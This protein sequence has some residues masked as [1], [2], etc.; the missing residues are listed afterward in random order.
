M[1][2]FLKIKSINS[3][4]RRKMTDPVMIV[5]KKKKFNIEN[6]A[7]RIFWWKSKH[8]TKSISDKQE[9]DSLGNL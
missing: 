9:K 5:Q 3:D 7:V 1:N 4:K 6:V 2:I 8:F